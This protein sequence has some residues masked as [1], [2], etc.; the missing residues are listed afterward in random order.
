ML[1][2]NKKRIS[3]EKENITPMEKKKGTQGRP[4]VS[5]IMPCYN[6][7]A[8]I[9][10]AVE[11]LRAQSWPKIEL[12]IVDDGSDDSNT[13][14]IIENL[15]FERK[16]LLH[17]EHIGPAAARNRGIAA[18]EGEFI[19][20]LDADDRIDPAYIKEAVETIQN[21]PDI[22]IVYC[23]ADLFGAASGP[24]ELPDYSFRTELLDNCIFVT[25]LFRKEDWQKAGGFCEDFT[26]GMEDYDFW[27]SLL[28]MGRE[29]C[30]LPQ[31]YF[32]YR[33]K[34]VS[35]T[36]RFQDNYANVQE[37]YLKLYQRHRKL[38][39][40]HMDLYCT[41]LRRNLID[42]LMMNRKLQAE[43]EEQKE[44]DVRQ[45]RTNQDELLMMSLRDDPLVEYVISVRRLKP[46]FGRFLEKLLHMKN[47]AKKCIGRE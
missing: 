14:E 5:V 13:R 40:N 26:A 18:A 34:A 32:H 15:R 30:Q 44:K 33:I 39:Q 3:A 21:N 36:T 29:V 16:R 25:S 37:T 23:H 8:Y 19:L 7:G 42:Q 38:F 2:E 45:I 9:G 1:S 11:S 47:K 41:E 4:T 6:D 12:I 22:G 28:E 10:E 46:R 17:T 31:V 43:K 35:R 20:P 27:L 24:W